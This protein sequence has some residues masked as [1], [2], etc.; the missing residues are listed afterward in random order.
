M[1]AIGLAISTAVADFTA[2]AVGQFLTQTIGG[3]LL[4]SVA[5]SALRNGQ[6]QLHA[7][8]IHHPH[9]F[10]NRKVPPQPEPWGQWGCFRS[11]VDSGSGDR[12]RRQWSH[13]SLTLNFEIAGL[14]PTAPPV[15]VLTLLMIHSDV[16]EATKV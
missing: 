7:L 11:G 16:V 8:T 3:R 15:F 6:A 13:S 4:T 2:T 10:V 1:P 5:L 9:R 14:P 12:S